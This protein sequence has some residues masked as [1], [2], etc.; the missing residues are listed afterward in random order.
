V[1]KD[2][3]I[4]EP[5]KELLENKKIKNKKVEIVR[6]TDKDNFEKVHIIFIPSQINTKDFKEIIGI[7]KI[8]HSLIISEKNGR[9]NLG[10][11]INF[12]LINNR[13][14]FEINLNTLKENKLK[15]GSQ[16][17]KLAEKVEQ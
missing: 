11:G 12:L 4:E 15:T 1:Y 9:L 8:K 3:P 16:L 17:L 2:S 13:I 7:E 10:A 6:F 5:L 14:K